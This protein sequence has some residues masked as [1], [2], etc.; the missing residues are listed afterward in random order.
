MD[1]FSNHVRHWLNS[2]A[3]EKIAK[4]K[5]GIG[6]PNRAVEDEALGSTEQQMPAVD[7][8]LGNGKFLLGDNVTIADNFAFAYMEMAELSQL[9]LADFPHVKNWYQEFKNRDSVVRAKTTLGLV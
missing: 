3:F 7:T 2:Y 9:S 8:R 4:V 5:F 6:E 1:F